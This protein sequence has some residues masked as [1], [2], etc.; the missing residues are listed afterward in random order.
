MR[1]GSKIHIIP[2]QQRPRRTKRATFA[3]FRPPRGPESSAGKPAETAKRHLRR[4][5]F[6]D[7]KG[8]ALC[9]EKHIRG[10][11]VHVLCRIFHV[12][13]RKSQVLCRK[14]HVLCGKIHIPCRTRHILFRTSHDF[15]RNRAVR[16]SVSQ[17]PCGKKKVGQRHIAV[18]PIHRSNRCQ[19]LL[20][21]AFTF[22]SGLLALR[23]AGL[24]AS[25]LS[26]AFAAALFLPVFPVLLAALLGL[27]RLFAA[28]LLRT[29]GIQAKAE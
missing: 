5:V 4:P 20:L 27:R 14:S 12:L 23:S 28:L 22:A 3:F 6:Q 11:N 1:Q 7:R 16:R 25:L 10:R 19:A 26:L 17:K 8:H 24:G 21:A 29:L 13:H 15:R 2:Q 18:R 9:R